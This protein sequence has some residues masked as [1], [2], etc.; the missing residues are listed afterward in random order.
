MSSQYAGIRNN[1]VCFTDKAIGTSQYV[2]CGI[3]G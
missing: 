1:Q 2:S 3:E